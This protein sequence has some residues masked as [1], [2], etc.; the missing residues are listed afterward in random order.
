MH[1]NCIYKCHSIMQRLSSDDVFEIAAA[2]GIP[3]TYMFVLLFVE[4]TFVQIP[5][6]LLVSWRS[7]MLFSYQLIFIGR[8]R[9]NNVTTIRHYLYLHHPLKCGCPELFCFESAW[10]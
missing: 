3:L 4:L 2:K 9:V 6:G 5:S 1:V 7:D 8:L 10:L